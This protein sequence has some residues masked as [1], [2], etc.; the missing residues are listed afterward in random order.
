MVEATAT[1]TATVQHP[2]A[3]AGA[4]GGVPTLRDRILDA[5]VRC[6]AATGVAKTTIDDIAGEASCS[7]ATVYRAFPGGKDAVVATAGIREVQRF[8]AHLGRRLDGC[9]TLEEALVAGIC[10]AARQF[11]HHDALR[12]L[13]VNEPAVLWPMVCFDGLDP[14][15][16]RAA[17]FAED[18]LARF[19]DAPTARMVGEWAAR[20]VL[21]YADEPGPGAPG[22]PT[23][24]GDAGGITADLADE[25]VTRHLVRT[26]L[27]PGLAATSRPAAGSPG[28]T[29]ST[30]PEE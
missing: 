27:L 24:P 18:R 22:A 2:H 4:A 10:E 1:A 29:S 7:R 28:T 20:L 5:T 25:G 15:L 23:V 19:L 21:V 17:S 6:I 14:V 16:A 11:H 12:Y 8:A 3:V 13:V 26:F 9:A 30:S